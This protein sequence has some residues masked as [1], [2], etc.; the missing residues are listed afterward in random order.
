MQERDLLHQRPTVERSKK[1]RGFQLCKVR[2][3][4]EVRG[5][6]NAK[7]EDTEEW[8][9]KEGGRKRGGGA[10]SVSPAKGDNLGKNN[11]S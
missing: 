8:K 3:R 6:A 4:T 10:D 1:V 11:N 9:A 2:S 5:W 7:T